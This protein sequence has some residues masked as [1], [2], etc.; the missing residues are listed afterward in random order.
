MS[1]T[2]RVVTREE[3]RI[4]DLDETDHALTAMG[5]PDGKEFCIKGRPPARPADGNGDAMMGDERR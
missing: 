5:D 4:D 2:C 1:P 3:T